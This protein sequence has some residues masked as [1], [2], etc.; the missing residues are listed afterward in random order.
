V[1]ACEMLEKPA[2]HCCLLRSTAVR[3]A[4]APSWCAELGRV[5]ALAAKQGLD[6]T[7]AQRQ[8]DDLMEALELSS[9]GS[10]TSAGAKGAAAAA[11]RE[12][13]QPGRDRLL[14]Y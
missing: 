9:A 6:L 11:D 4:G 8:R 1:S 5:R 12:E 3:R 2:D 7:E 10:P 13:E 14:A